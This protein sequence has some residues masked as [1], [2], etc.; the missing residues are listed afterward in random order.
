MNDRFPHSF[1]IL[2]PRK[3]NG[4]L[5]MDDEGNPIYDTLPLSKVR[6][7]DGDPIKRNGSFV[8]DEVME[9]SF[10]YR[11]S[12]KSARDTIDVVVTEFKIATPMFTTELLTGDVIV[13]QDY[14]RAYKGDVV[15]K[16]S[17]NWGTNIWFNENRN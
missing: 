13:L 8:T 6:M 10:G 7:L 3:S 17:F 2:R 12:T 4:R 15:K 11:T 1:H 14:D 9:L 16:M 5:V